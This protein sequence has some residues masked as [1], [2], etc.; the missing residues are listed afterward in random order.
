MVTVSSV[1]KRRMEVIR[2]GYGIFSVQTKNGGY[3]RWL[4][5]LQ[6]THVEWGLYEVVTVSSVYKRR[7]MEVI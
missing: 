7:M 3:M 6:C 2:G 1:Y 4:R 5:Y